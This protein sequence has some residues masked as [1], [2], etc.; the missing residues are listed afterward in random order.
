[1]MTAGTLTVAGFADLR[2]LKPGFNLF[3][4]Q[5]DIEVGHEAAL[6][7]E[8]EQ[9]LVRN[10]EINNYLTGLVQRLA[11]SPHAGTDFPFSVKAISDKTVNAF[12]LPGGPL[13]VYTG[14][15]SLADNEGQLAGVLAH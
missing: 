11:H 10:S 3:S 5:Q 12:A 1:M 9:P 2:D 15:I 8:K 6:Q 14:L 13:Y 4:P 7:V